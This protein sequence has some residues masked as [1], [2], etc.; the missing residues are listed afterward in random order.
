MS[1]E[2]CVKRNINIKAL[3]YNHLP[4]ENN[5]I[6]GESRNVFKKYLAENCPGTLF[7]DCP[8]VEKTSYPL[9]AINGLF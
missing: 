9:I 4:G 5:L 7:V 8:V 2:I 1:L 6:A 3:V